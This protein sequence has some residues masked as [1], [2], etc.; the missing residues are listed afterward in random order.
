[1][2]IEN[3]GSVRQIEHSLPIGSF[4]LLEKDDMEKCF[5]WVNLR[6]INSTENNSKIVKVDSFL[7]QLQQIKA[8]YFTKLNV[9]EI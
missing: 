3:Y 7:Y 1:M 6:P 8:I 9:E 5:N 4:N 2:T